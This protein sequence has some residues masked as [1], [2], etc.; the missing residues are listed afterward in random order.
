VRLKPTLLYRENGSEVEPE[1]VTSPR[2]KIRSNVVIIR[3]AGKNPFSK[4]GYP[5]RA[6]IPLW[7]MLPTELLPKE[8]ESAFAEACTKLVMKV[9]PPRKRSLAVF[10]HG[11]VD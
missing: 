9:E 3:N 1:N 2:W 5:L 7:Q 8:L 6:G 4:L 10:Q 11:P